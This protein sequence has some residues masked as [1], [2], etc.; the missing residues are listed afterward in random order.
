M[1][2][3]F[4]QSLSVGQKPSPIGLSDCDERIVVAYQKSL[5]GGHA[6]RNFTKAAIIQPKNINVL[7][8]LERTRHRKGIDNV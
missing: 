4:G 8:I 1:L 6:R 5:A 7:S 2:R 3:S